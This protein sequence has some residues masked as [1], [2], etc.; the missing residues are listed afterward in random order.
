MNQT[1]LTCD[2]KWK[3]HHKHKILWLE[4]QHSFLSSSPKQS[5]SALG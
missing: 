1:W 4:L 5:L 3:C 2:P